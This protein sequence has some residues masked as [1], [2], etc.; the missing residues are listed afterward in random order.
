M[1]KE[2]TA[3]GNV[4]TGSQKLYGLCLTAG[5]AAASVVVDDSTDGSGTTLLTLKCATNNH[6]VVWTFNQPVG[7]TTGIY[8]TL[9]GTGAK[10]AALY[11][12]GID[13]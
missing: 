6:S 9:S 13:A 7:F 1:L 11:G 2:L 4:A 8:L 10:A 5:G 3:T 12:P